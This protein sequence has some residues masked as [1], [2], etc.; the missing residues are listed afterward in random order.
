MPELTVH[1]RHISNFFELFRDDE[2]ALTL[3]LGWALR[4]SPHL[5]GALL[6]E[7]FGHRVDAQQG[8]IRLQ[9]HESKH[10]YTDI[11]IDLPNVCA[12][13]E[14]KRGWDLPGRK[15]LAR[16]AAR[17]NFRSA[18]E[19]RLVVLNES[20]S[21]YVEHNLDVPKRL[22]SLVKPVRWQWLIAAAEKVST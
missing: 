1:R 12:V 16:Y 11:E 18:K 19:K 21:E 20:V 13:I 15:Q 6:E 22:R 14:A 2:N 8:V 4:Q 9:H 7:I 3:A 5:F 10:G 17:K